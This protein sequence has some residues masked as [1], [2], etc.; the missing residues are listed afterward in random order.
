[1]P[2]QMENDCATPGQAADIGLCAY[3][4]AT[5]VAESQEKATAPPSYPGRRSERLAS[6]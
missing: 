2:D 3:F 5:S 6:C 4:V 1:M